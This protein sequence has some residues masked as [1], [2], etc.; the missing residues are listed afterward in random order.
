MFVKTFDFVWFYLTHGVGTS[1]LIYKEKGT[2]PAKKL[3]EG[4]LFQE[5]I[6]MKTHIIFPLL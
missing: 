6:L 3:Q 1:I 5:L 2:R 4:K